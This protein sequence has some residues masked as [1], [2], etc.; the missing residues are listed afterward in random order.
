MG[1][2]ILGKVGVST[3]DKVSSPEGFGYCHGTGRQY[4]RRYFLLLTVPRLTHNVV[5]YIPAAYRYLHT[6][7]YEV[8]TLLLLLHRHA[9]PFPPLSDIASTRRLCRRLYR[10]LCHS[11]LWTVNSLFARGNV[12]FDSLTIRPVRLASTCGKIEASTSDLSHGP[13]GWPFLGL[14]RFC[15]AHLIVR[16]G[17]GSWGWSGAGVWRLESQWSSG[18]VA[19]IVTDIVAP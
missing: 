3:V 4:I 18:P 11:E 7:T 9:P 16:D 10:R 5:S 8:S 19:D 12:W 2:L 6:S 1:C 15:C 14:P 17:S 13:I